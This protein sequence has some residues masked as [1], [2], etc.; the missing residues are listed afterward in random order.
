VSPVN[1]QGAAWKFGN[2][3]NTDLIFP[4]HYFKP[5]YE[6]GEMGRALLSGADPEFAGKLKRGDIIVGG[7]NFGCGSSREEAA[8]AMKEAGVGAIVASTFGRLFM[9][10]CINLGVPVVVSPGIAE[11]TAEGDRLEL[12]LADGLIINHSS[13]YRVRFP[14]MAPEL[15]SLLSDGGLHEYTVKELQ[16]RRATA[17]KR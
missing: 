4:N 8:G 9:R 12:D 5:A 14:T 3:I 10:N 7:T 11:H 1:I 13:G 17:G 2:N 15:L 6:P 16:R